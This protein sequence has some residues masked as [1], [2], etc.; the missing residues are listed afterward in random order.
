MCV[1]RGTRNASFSENFPYALTEW[2]HNLKT[3]LLWRE[4]SYSQGIA[5]KGIPKTRPE[6]NRIF[7][8]ESR[9][10]YSKSISFPK[11][12]EKS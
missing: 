4:A 1:Y 11:L 6:T 3:Y 10:E 12:T 2:S 5:V 8:M 7:S 9:M